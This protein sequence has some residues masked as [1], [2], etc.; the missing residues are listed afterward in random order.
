MYEKN[1]EVTKA[2][3]NEREMTSIV[4]LGVYVESKI[5]ILLVRISG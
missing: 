4:V 1:N 3:A 5:L 2:Y